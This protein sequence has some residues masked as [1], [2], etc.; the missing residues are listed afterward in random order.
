MEI[1]LIQRCINP[2]LEFDYTRGQSGEIY[3]FHN[4]CFIATCEDWQE[5]EEEQNEILEREMAV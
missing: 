2:L 3:L 1:I 4:G 5:V